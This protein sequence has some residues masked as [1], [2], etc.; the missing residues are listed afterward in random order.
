MKKGSV[1]VAIIAVVF[2]GYLLLQNQ[3]LQE[4]VTLATEAPEEEEETEQQGIEALSMEHEDTFHFDAEE[5]ARLFIEGYFGFTDH[6]NEDEVLP[7]VSTELASNLNFSEQQGLD[8]DEDETPQIRNSVAHL[9]FYYGEYTET[10]QELFATFENHIRVDDVESSA[11][12]YLTLDMIDDEG[13]WI[14][15]DMTFDQH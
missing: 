5:N 4:E 13:E 2:I 12:S 1:F 10:R 9:K 3:Q 8:D 15:E 6:P 14:V 11:K 7:Y